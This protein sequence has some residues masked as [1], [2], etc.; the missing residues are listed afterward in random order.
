MR[1]L[2]VISLA[3]AACACGAATS[4]PDESEPDT[5]EPSGP[6]E[7]SLAIG[8]TV[9]DAVHGTCS[10]A[11]VE[12]LSAQIVA[13]MNCMIPGALSEVPAHPRF[14]K[15]A[16]TFP[17]MQTAARD[18]LVGA[19]A[20]NPGMTLSVSSMLRT[21][22]QQYLLHRWSL[23]GRCGIAIAATPGKSNHESGLAIDIGQH[24]AWRSALGA[25]GFH[26]FGSADKV[27]F[28]YA[29]TGRANLKGVDVEAF[30][31]LWNLNNPSDPIDEDGIYGTQTGK[32]LAKSPVNGFPIGASCGN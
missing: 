27:H 31:I 16:A 17:F 18:A 32:R 9:E 20:A 2:L 29:G 12:G 8:S 14:V 15:S 30:Q 22:A 26:W 10:T 19:L 28:D 23:S 4:A 5:E 6:A 11:S 7:V 3:L 21:V 1:T 25:K 13:Q 24:A